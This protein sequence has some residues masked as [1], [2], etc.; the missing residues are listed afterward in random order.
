MNKIALAGN[1][2]VGKSTVF[3]AL[4]GMNQHTGNWAGKTVSNAVG[5]YTYE[6]EKYEIYD[7]PGT[8]SLLSNSKEEKQARDFLCFEEYDIA[9]VVCD[10]TCLLRNLNLVLQILEITPNVLLCLNLMDEAK[11]KKIQIDI[12][13]LKNILHIPIVATTA[14]DKKGLDYLLQEI[15]NLIQHPKTKQYPLNYSNSIEESIKQITPYLPFSNRKRFFAL[16]LMREDEEIIESLKEKYQFERNDEI[17][18]LLQRIK[19]TLLEEDIIDKELDDYI[20]EKINQEAEKIYQDVITVEDESKTEKNR[21]IDRIVTSKIFGI[22]MMLGLLFIIFWLTMYVSNYPSDFLFQFFYQFEEP[23]Y[24]FLQQFLPDFFSDMIAHG[25]YKTLYWVVS[26]MLPPMAIFFPLF[27]ILEDLGYLPRIAF[28][29]DKIFKKCSSCGKQALTMCMG[30]GC[31]AVGVEGARIIDS[32]RERMMSILTNNFIPCNG[33]FPTLLALISMFIVGISSS[34]A[35]SL[36]SALILTLVILLGI[37]TSLIVSKILSKTLL[38]GVPSSFSL[39]LPP[40]RSPKIGSILIRSLLDRTLFVLFRAIAVAVPA[41]IIIWLFANIHYH[42]TSLLLS[43]ASFLDTP[44]KV[45]GMDGMILLAFIL[46]FPANEIVIPIILMGY[47]AT[48]TMIDFSNLME[49]KNILIQNGWTIV[50][51]LSVLIFSLMHWPCSTTCLTI[52]K[53]TKSWKW[54]ILA[55]AIPTICGLTICFLLNL[56]ASLF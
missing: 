45:F 12:N 2:N 9:V 53:E 21:K 37:F 29:V 39:E 23:L 56:V 13:K 31:N 54:T 27:T 18:Q 25:A 50:T 36:L 5:Y 42:D 48:S 1:P 14:R 15:K 4:T 55:M 49:L 11:K 30:F 8:Y 40:Y 10:A 19:I 47:L 43:I 33:R 38:K 3:N 34:I 32:K 41:G 28:N 16:Q 6:N 20:V 7:L 17:N 44:A 51:A 24:H 52:H 22:P 26:V 35:S 46:G